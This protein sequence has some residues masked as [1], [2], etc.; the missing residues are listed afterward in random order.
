LSL[1]TLM[2]PS[3]VGVESH[4]KLKTVLLYN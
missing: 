2:K 3:A 1:K 4:L